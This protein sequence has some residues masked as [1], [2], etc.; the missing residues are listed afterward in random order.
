MDKKTFY[1]CDKCNKKLIERLPNGLWKFAFGRQ[2]I[3]FDESGE[4]LPFDK[5]QYEPAVMMLIR[6]SIKIK[7]LKREC[8]HYNILPFFPNST[9][10]VEPQSELSE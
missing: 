7:C 2:R 3:E 4:A 6:G 8:G 1:K 5:D 9:D 10:F